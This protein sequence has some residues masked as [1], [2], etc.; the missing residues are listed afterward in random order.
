MPSQRYFLSEV[1]LQGIYTPVLHSSLQYLEGIMSQKTGANLIQA[2]R[3][4]FG[5]HGFEM[6]QEPG[7]HHYAWEPIVR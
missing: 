4:Y 5:N 3:D 6:I 1:I 7:I 2:Q